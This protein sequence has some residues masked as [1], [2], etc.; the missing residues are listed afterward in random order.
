[1]SGKRPLRGRAILAAGVIAVV[2]VIVAIRWGIVAPPTGSG[3]GIDPPFLYDRDELRVGSG[4]LVDDLP[5]GVPVLCYHY[6]RPDFKAGY[7]VRVLGSVIFGMPALSDREFWTTSHAEFER[8][9]KWFRDT[10]TRVMTLDEVADLL[11]AG[12]PLPRRAVVLTID[13]A[14]RSVYE[15]AWPLLQEYGVQ[16]HL[17]V[18]TDQVASQWSSLEVCS[19]DELREMADSGA[20]VIGSHTRNMHYKVKTDAGWEPVFWHPTS[21]PLDEAE[22]AMAEVSGRWDELRGAG[23]VADP[24]VVLGDQAGPVLADLLASRLD[25]MDETG[26]TP[27]WLAWPYGF[28]NDRLD[29]L[30]HV[31]GFRGT[32]SLSPHVVSHADSSRALGRITLTARNTTSQ[33]KDVM[34]AAAR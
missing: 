25:I 16:A 20:V 24:S 22:A 29:S 18:P 28:A 14:D 31:V 33:I 34:A 2:I 17:F 21:L 30:A 27:Y 13:D 5:G 1:M 3:G 15:V 7:L 26:H 12:E 8:H 11:D 10:G 32:V 19:W 4:S 6:F 23:V 9:L